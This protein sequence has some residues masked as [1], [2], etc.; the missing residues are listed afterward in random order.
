MFVMPK[1]SRWR[2]FP[3]TLLG[4]HCLSTGWAPNLQLPTIT[5]FNNKLSSDYYNILYF[6]LDTYLSHTESGS[7]QEFFLIM[8]NL[9]EVY[10]ATVGL[11][12]LWQ[13]PQC[14]CFEKNKIKL[15]HT[16]AILD[17][18]VVSLV[19]L[20]V[21]WNMRYYG[22]VLVLSIFIGIIIEITLLWQITQGLHYKQSKAGCFFSQRDQN[23]D[24][25]C[26]N[27]QTVPNNCIN[28]L[29]TGI[30]VEQSQSQRTGNEHHLIT[31]STSF[32]QDY[33]YNVLL[34]YIILMSLQI[35]FVM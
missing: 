34:I 4:S 13:S 20:P 16:E 10:L 17:D 23:I 33:C 7:S 2:I 21:N 24:L 32:S 31:R 8:L 15:N 30:F 9:Q 3:W 26:K 5:L 14:C 6:G 12:V 35:S 18:Y 19:H 27:Y 28:Y 25:A 1:A 29:H 22:R 11:L